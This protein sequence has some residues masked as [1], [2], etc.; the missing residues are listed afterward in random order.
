[1]RAI[2]V[3]LGETRKITDSSR[4]NDDSTVRSDQASRGLHWFYSNGKSSIVI[5]DG[6]VCVATHV[7]PHSFHLR[8]KPNCKS[9]GHGCDCRC[10]QFLLLKAL[11]KL[12]DLL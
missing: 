11:S 6:G 7:D 4:Y 2:D 12:F 8:W 1:M 5:A 10:V 3:K 9:S